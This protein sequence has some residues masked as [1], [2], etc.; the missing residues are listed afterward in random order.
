M[1]ERPSMNDRH[2]GF[3]QKVMIGIVILCAVGAIISFTLLASHFSSDDF[4]KPIT[5]SLDE[6][7]QDVLELTAASTGTS[8]GITVLPGDIATPIA[9]KMANVSTYLLVVMC[10]IYLEKYLITILG[11]LTFKYLIPIGLIFI[12]AGQ[13]RKRPNWCRTGGRIAL[14]GLAI[15]LVIPLS[16]RVSDI[17]SDSYQ[18]TLNQTLES[19]EKTEQELNAE[20]EKLEA[21][22]AE[23]GESTKSAAA[24]SQNGKTAAGNSGNTK[25]ST[26]GNN[27]AAGNNKATGNNSQTSGNSQSTTATGKNSASTEAAAA[28]DDQDE[29]KPTIWQRITGIPS[30]VADTATS[31]LTGAS[32]VTQE[33]I[34]E[35]QTLLNNF[36]ESVAVMI[37]TSC[38]IPILVLLFFIYVIKLLFDYKPTFDGN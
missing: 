25:Q 17:I 32:E 36:L 33:K 10:A 8:I 5:T 26:T 2:F 9:E 35:L 30:A 20:R 16:V 12:G 18:A 14:F 4:L 29:E 1:R 28:K 6:K 34:E 15:F 21:E 22:E 7:K 19:A 27:K 24:A 23:A 3:D 13:V 31:A 37:I 38:V 11:L